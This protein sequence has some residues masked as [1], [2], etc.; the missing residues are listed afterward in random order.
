MNERASFFLSE[1]VLESMLACSR[2]EL[3]YHM[4][5]CS[6]ACIGYVEYRHV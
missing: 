6:Y 5:A 2:E 3:F 1:R 4:A